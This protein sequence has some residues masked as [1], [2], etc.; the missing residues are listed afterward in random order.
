M[1]TLATVLPF[2]VCLV[3][4]AILALDCRKGQSDKLALCLFGITATLLYLCHFLH[5]NG[6]QS[7]FS[8]SIY[9]LCNLSVYPMYTIY[10]RRLTRPSEKHWREELLYFLPAALVF[11]QS[12]TGILQETDPRLIA[13]WLFP[14]VSLIA[15]YDAARRLFQFRKEVDNYYSNPESKRLNPVLILVGLQLVTTLA[16]IVSNLLGRETF[17]Q[18]SLL[19][20]PSCTFAVLLFCIF[21][22]S[23]RTNSPA[24]E[25][26]APQPSDEESGF[27]TEQQRRL[28]QKIDTLMQEKELFRTK[29]LTVNDIAEAVGSNR[30][31]V[32]LCINQLGGASFS[33]Y[34][35]TARVK[36]AQK[37]IQEHPELPLSEVADM[38]G[39]N[40]RT[41]FY[42]NFKKIAG[43]AP[44]EYLQSQKKD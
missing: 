14:V 35:N 26:Q 36:Y 17:Q 18:S 12:I 32:S 21:Y 24:R 1:Y 3:W 7:R 42:R 22:V 43:V 29:G 37:L 13:L 28:L 11:V 39:F 33:D 31:Y 4:T 19:W 44:G 2:M 20:I 8:E 25:M 9:F 34:V 38:A 6:M 30:T 15:S 16:S 27:N 40:E 41:S 5:F 23:S 10:V